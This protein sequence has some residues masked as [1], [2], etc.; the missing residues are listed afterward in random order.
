MWGASDGSDLRLLTAAGVPTLQYG[1]GD[2]AVAHGPRESV[3]LAE[4]ATAA[5]GGG[6]RRWRRWRPPLRALAVLALQVCGTA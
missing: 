3:P 6:D 4:V 1:P 2:A 5:G